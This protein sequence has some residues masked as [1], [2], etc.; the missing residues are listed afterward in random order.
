MC[1]RVQHILNLYDSIVYAGKGELT[2]SNSMIQ[3]D[4]DHFDTILNN[5]YQCGVVSRSSKLLMC[6]K[7]SDELSEVFLE[8]LVTFGV[9][10]IFKLYFEDAEYVRV[11]GKGIPKHI[12]KEIEALPESQDKVSETQHLMAFT[13]KNVKL[14]IATTTLNSQQTGL[15]KDNL[16]QLVDAI[17]A[18]V[19]NYH[20]DRSTKQQHVNDKVVSAE[21]LHEVVHCLNKLN[22]HLIESNR[23]I[24]QDLYSN[25]IAKF[26]M[27]ALEADQEESILDIMKDALDR[28][29]VLMKA[30]V[31]HNDELKDIL[32][33]AI[34]SLV[35]DIE[36]HFS[37][38]GLGQNSAL[39]GSQ[40][41]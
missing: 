23:Q 16:M 36:E 5:A 19:E 32:K 1:W 37:F 35:E 7:L 11:V 39:A 6:C 13:T 3:I 26:P 14:V 8:A 27:L 17:Q 4:K 38:K 20:F 34:N 10:G 9:S 40:V 24:S 12:F 33:Q 31:H 18:W 2:V 15:Y 30:Q 41:F 25:L 28:Q 22:L 29:D 21:R